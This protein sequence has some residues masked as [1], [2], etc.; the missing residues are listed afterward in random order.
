MVSKPF[1]GRHGAEIIFALAMLVASG[2]A[3]WASIGLPPGVLEPIGPAVFPRATAIILALLALVVLGGAIARRGPARSRPAA[4][5]PRL[6]L[7][8]LLLSISYIGAMEVEWLGF[9]DATVIYLVTLSLMLVDFDRRKIP[10]IGV[11]A[12]VIGIGSHY[13]FTGLFYIDLP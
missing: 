10:T 6:A 4:D 1:S 7:G 8:S 13:L 2:V 9:R 3:W 5:R 11:I 12:L